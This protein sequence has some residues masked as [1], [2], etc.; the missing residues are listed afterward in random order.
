MNNL[1]RDWTIIGLQ[2]NHNLD[3]IG[4]QCEPQMET[5]NL[6]DQNWTTF[7]DMFWTK[8]LATIGPQFGQHLDLILEHNWTTFQGDS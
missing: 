2:L 7:E 5:L 6:L 1:D 3:H 8:I 4:L